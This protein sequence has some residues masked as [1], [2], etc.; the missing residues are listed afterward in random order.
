MHP[1]A[2]IPVGYPVSEP[3]ATKRRPLNEVMTFVGESEYDDTAETEETQR[4]IEHSDMGDVIFND[5]NLGNS[6]FTDINF[7]GVDISAA[8]LTNG[9]IHD[10]N[11][12]N[13]QIYD[14]IL[15]GMTINGKD[16]CELLQD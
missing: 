15:D 5:V 1:I 10:C 11:L 4:K 16:I 14:C 12:S 7:Y 8:N 9:K 3:I 13:F 6:K 2:I